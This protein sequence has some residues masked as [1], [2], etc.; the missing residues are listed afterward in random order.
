MFF[1]TIVYLFGGEYTGDEVFSFSKVTWQT[2]AMIIHK[3]SQQPT[4]WDS[5]YALKFSFCSLHSPFTNI[6]TPFTVL[7]PKRSSTVARATYK[8]KN[9]PFPVGLLGESL[10]TLPRWKVYPARIRS[11]RF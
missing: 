10:I 4:T 5:C 9:G 2:L 3:A 7:V 11:L 8:K 1:Y 6:D